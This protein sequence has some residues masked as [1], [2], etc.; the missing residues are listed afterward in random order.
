MKKRSVPMSHDNK[1]GEGMKKGLL[2][3][4]II[5]IALWAAT[6]LTEA[7]AASSSQSGQQYDSVAQ[8]LKTLQEEL[9]VKKTELAQ[10]RHKWTINKGRT[11]TEKEL[12]EFE[13]KR[14]KGEAKTEDNPYVNKSSLSSPGRWREAYYKKLDEIKK[15]EE[16]AVRLERE[17]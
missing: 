17:L 9:A 13:E 7:G 3:I 15:D 8:E 14:A 5:A 10:L 2:A 12:K 1:V 6:S 16:R 4:C 11:P